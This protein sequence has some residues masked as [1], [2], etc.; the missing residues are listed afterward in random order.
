MILYLSFKAFY[1]PFNKMVK[2]EQATLLGEK[3]DGT[4]FIMWGNGLQS[5]L[6]LVNRLF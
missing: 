3:Q 2:T 1:E 4:A 5:I 6:Q